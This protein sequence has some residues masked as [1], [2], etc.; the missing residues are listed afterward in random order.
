MRKVAIITTG[1]AM[2]VSVV[3]SVASQER[4]FVEK[5][6]RLYIRHC[7]ACHGMDGKG[8]GPAADSLKVPPPDLTQ[9]QKAG[10]AFPIY[11]VMAVIE[12][13]KVVPAH[14]TREMPIWG[15]I[16]RR[17]RGEALMRSDIY[18]LARYI[19]AIQAKR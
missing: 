11:R 7:A 5:G 18:A 9:L 16:F 19:E 6:R 8:N 1:V 14:G 15:T 4:S 10:E 12:G 2:L 3:M 17:T 13:E